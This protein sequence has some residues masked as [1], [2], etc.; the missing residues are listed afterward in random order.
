MI[1]VL[2]FNVQVVIASVAFGMGINCVGVTK[3]I[4]YSPPDSTDSYIQ[5]IGRGGHD[6]QSYIS[7]LLWSPTLNCYADDDMKDYCLNSTSCRRDFLFNDYDN[8]T[9]NAKSKCCCCDVW[10]N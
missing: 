9:N 4:H 6:G 1:N 10:C 8:Y 3:I 7:L 2:L 5:Q